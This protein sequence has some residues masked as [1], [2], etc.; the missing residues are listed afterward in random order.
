[1]RFL[2][3]KKSHI[4]ALSVVILQNV[5]VIYIVTNVYIMRNSMLLKSY[6]HAHFVIIKPAQNMG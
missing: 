2:I 3:I 1:M 5:I 4:N 6:L